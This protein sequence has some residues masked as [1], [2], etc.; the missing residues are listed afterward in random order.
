MTTKLNDLI[1]ILICED[2]QK[3]IAFYCEVLGFEV[4]NRMNDVGKSDWASLY[5]GRVQLMLGSPTY[6]PEEKNRWQILA[7]D[8]LFLS[9]RCGSVA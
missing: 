3:S 6:L 2:V 7:G 4:T 8:L 9:R 1:P 5:N